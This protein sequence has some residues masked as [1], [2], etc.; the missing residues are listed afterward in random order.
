MKNLIYRFNNWFEYELKNY[1]NDIVR[2]I[3]NLIRWF[4]TI[5]KDRDWD[6]DF[7]WK[8]I[9]KKLEFQSEYLMLSGKHTSS[10]RDAE[11]IMTCVNLI[12]RVKTEYYLTEYQD[13]QELEMNFVPRTLEDGGKSYEYKPNVLS[14]SFDDYFR[15][16]PIVYKKVVKRMISE[17]KTYDKW[18]VAFE[19]SR[20]NHKR[21]KKLLFSIMEN[22]I[23]NWWD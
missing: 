1:P 22:N 18:R 2:G 17:K 21:A 10:Q 6:I 11:I 8:M 14:E 13:Y 3:E 20:E 5:W 9:S 23:E 12:E 16:Y 15:K 4:P 7:T 19:M